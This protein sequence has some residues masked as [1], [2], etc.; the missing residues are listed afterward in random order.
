M[1]SPEIAGIQLLLRELAQPAR[2]LLLQP[3]PLL[4]SASVSRPPCNSA[5]VVATHLQPVRNGDIQPADLPDPFVKNV[6]RLRRLELRL[7]NTSTLAR[8]SS[9]REPILP[10]LIPVCPLRPPMK[11]TY[12]HRRV[13]LPV[14]RHGRSETQ[15]ATS[16]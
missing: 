7:H 10:A 5:L 8:A 12:Q 2:V 11:Q 16:K 14:Q 13:L 4:P 6:R 9:L 3:S 15:S 1:A